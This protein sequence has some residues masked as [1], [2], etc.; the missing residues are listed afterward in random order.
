MYVASIAFTIQYGNTCYANSVIQALY[1]S[2]A[3]RERVLNVPDE[4]R[5]QNPMLDALCEL[6]ESLSQQKKR[7]GSF[8]PKR[9]IE[10]LRKENVL[11]SGF[12]QQDAQEFL[13]YLLNVVAEH[14]KP[15]E[16]QPKKQSFV[17]ELFRGQLS[18]DIRCI[19][20]ECTSSRKETF[21]DLSVDVRQN[22]SLS[23]CLRNFSRSET[24]SGENKFYCESCRHYQEAQKSQK[25]H[26]MPQLFIA[27]L[28]RFKYDEMV[29]GYRKLS[30]R[31]AFPLEIR[32][33]THNQDATS[34][35]LYDLYAIVIHVGSGPNSG[36][37]TTL[38]KDRGR[39]LRFDDVRVD[40]VHEEDL[41]TVF[42]F[43]NSQSIGAETAYL[44]FYQ[45]HQSTKATRS[46]RDTETPSSE[47]DE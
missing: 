8:S 44:L 14:T 31:V 38:I 22:I 36:H 28:K 7:V 41:D 23:Q 19:T 12:Q 27:H 17:D 2:A 26:R 45:Q 29:H 15:K 37:Y 13:N 5:Q 11:F 24:L 40:L 3:F 42:G 25:I 47:Q 43:A 35:P 1:Y 46:T 16:K 39:W 21:L 4:Y 30:Y 6:F 18:T 20:C 34:Y 33:C 10:V 32:M 9:F